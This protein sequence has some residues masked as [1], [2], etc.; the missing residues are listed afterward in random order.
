MKN[1]SRTFNV[2]AAP[3]IA[4]NAL[5]TGALSKFQNT[6]L[7]NNWKFIGIHYEV[8]QRLLKSTIKLNIKV[9]LRNDIRFE[10]TVRI[11]VYMFCSVSYLNG[12]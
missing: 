4:S 7:V 9:Y 6:K 12:I 11:T 1:G 8:R 10:T 5:Q 2:D 3:V